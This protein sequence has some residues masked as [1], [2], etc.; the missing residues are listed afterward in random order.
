MCVCVWC[1]TDQSKSI[2]LQS[3]S[4]L[5]RKSHITQSR[6]TA[7]VEGSEQRSERVWSIVDTIETYLTRIKLMR[8]GKKVHINDQY[9]ISS[10]IMR[11]TLIQSSGPTS[12]V[13]VV[14]S[15]SSRS[16]CAC[17][18]WPVAMVMGTFHCMLSN[19]DTHTHTHTHTHMHTHD[20]SKE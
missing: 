3:K 17:L 12:I 7:E 4:I 9:N 11:S 5:R 19:P 14:L 10:N 15:F 18:F 20:N 1:V 2:I 6:S 13:T 16:V 8:G